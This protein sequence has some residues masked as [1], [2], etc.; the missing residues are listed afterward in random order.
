MHQTQKSW[1]NV[2]KFSICGILTHLS[3]PPSYQ[4][5]LIQSEMAFWP[6]V[7]LFRPKLSPNRTKNGVFSH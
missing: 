4:I 2:Q 1:L 7:K 3:R 6:N 5:E